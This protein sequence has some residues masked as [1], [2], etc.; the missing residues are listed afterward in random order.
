MYITHFHISNHYPIFNSHKYH[1]ISIIVPFYLITPIT[2]L[3]LG[4][5]HGSNQ[6]HQFGT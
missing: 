1:P 5:I 6:T 2:W 3:G 4:R